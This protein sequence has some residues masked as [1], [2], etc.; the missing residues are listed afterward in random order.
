MR[1]LSVYSVMCGV[2]E[3]ENNVTLNTVSVVDEQVADRG[4]V[5][6]EVHADT[7]SRDRYKV[8]VYSANKGEVV[9][10][11]QNYTSGEEGR[12]ILYFPSFSPA[13]P[14]ADP[15]PAIVE[16]DT[17]PNPPGPFGRVV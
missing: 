13:V 12:D 10:M 5:W 1:V 9:C 3:T 17:T 8:L 11:L 14:T 7:L 6:D 15:L 16:F 4:T 2:I